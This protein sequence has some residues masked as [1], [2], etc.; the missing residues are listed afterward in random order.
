[1]NEK[2]LKKVLKEAVAND[3]IKTGTKEVFQY[4]K[5]TNLLLTSTSLPGHS[6]EKAKKLSEDSNIS[7]YDFP[8]NSTLL[9][10]LCGLS[11]RTS[12]VSI[13]GVSE[14]D[15]KSILS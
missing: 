11:Y 2:K 15:V 10:R 14:D 12:I 13:K 9:G 7:L 5:G 4:I 6:L 8:G 1:M 3:K